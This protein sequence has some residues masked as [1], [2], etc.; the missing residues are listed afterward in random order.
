MI[1]A[2]VLVVWVLGLVFCI[3]L[4]RAAAT[5]SLPDRQPPA[6]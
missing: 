4:G 1:I 6:S 5:E 2:I 3:A